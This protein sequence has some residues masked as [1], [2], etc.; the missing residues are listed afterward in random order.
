MAD[1][2]QRKSLLVSL[3]QAGK[4]SDHT[5]FEEFNL[6]PDVEFE[7]SKQETYQQQVAISIIQSKLQLL[8]TLLSSQVGKYTQEPE[9]DINNVS[10]DTDML[11]VLLS[12]NS[13]EEMIN[14]NAFQEFLQFLSTANPQQKQEVLNQLSSMNSIY[15]T[16]LDA[17]QNGNS[18]GDYAQA[19]QVQNNVAQIPGQEQSTDQ[20]V[21]NTNQMPEKQAPKSNNYGI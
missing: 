5:I 17:W 7:R 1:D 16:L 13:V 14:S 3:N 21:V 6:D 2:L 20:G 9:I 11:K 19:Q 12:S 4:V 15:T 18:V 8:Q 10:F